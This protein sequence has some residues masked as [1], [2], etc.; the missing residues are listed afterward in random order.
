MLIL[1]RPP[2]PGPDCEP[3]LWG[4]PSPS[5]PP[6]SQPR[7]RSRGASWPKGSHPTPSAHGR[8]D[9]IA[10]GGHLSR[11]RRAAG[12][13]PRRAEPRPSVQGPGW[14]LGLPSAGT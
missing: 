3:E 12:G 8:A 6:P 7:Y 5:S 1:P 13:A 11:S 2:A 10:R 14:G 4:A 9:V